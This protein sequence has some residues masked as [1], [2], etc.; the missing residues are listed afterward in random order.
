M[1]KMFNEMIYRVTGDHQENN[2]NNGRLFSLAPTLPWLIP[3]PR[4]LCR[5][6]GRSLAPLAWLSMVSAQAQTLHPAALSSGALG[7]F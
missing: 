5:E 6:L 2:E 3:I 4:L 7:A 1:T